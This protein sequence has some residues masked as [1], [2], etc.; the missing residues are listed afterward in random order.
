M[1][2]CVCVCVCVYVCVCMCV[3]VCV[4]VCV[5]IQVSCVLPNCNTLRIIMINE[6]LEM[7]FSLHKDKCQSLKITQGLNHISHLHFR[8]MINHL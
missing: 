7:N 5:C 4:C 2:V 8:V 6:K 1:Y 3:Y